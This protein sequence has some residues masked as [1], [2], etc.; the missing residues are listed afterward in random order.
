[1][2][3]VIDTNCLSD[4]ADGDKSLALALKSA[5]QIYIPVIVLGEYRYGILNSRLKV[6]RT[7]WLDE[8]EKALRVLTITT[9]T[10]K[11]YALVRNDLKKAGTPIPENDIWIAAQ[12]LDA[13]A[14]I[15]SKDTHFDYVPGLNRIGW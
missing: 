13:N 9:S 5:E 3:I 11:R 7:K 10:A 6:Q 2:D 8:L 14:A 1:M 15:A 4:W 12:C